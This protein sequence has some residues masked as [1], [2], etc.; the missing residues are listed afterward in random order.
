MPCAS[1]STGISAPGL[2][3]YSAMTASRRSRSSSSVA[4]STQP[5]HAF[6]ASLIPLSFAWVRCDRFADAVFGS[7]VRLLEGDELREVLWYLRA[8][9][10]RA[11]P[12]IGQ[13]DPELDLRVGHDHSGD[14]GGDVAQGRAIDVAQPHPGAHGDAAELAG[15][16]HAEPA[17]GGLGRLAEEAQAEAG[18]LVRL[19]REERVEGLLR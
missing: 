15:P 3:L 16:A 5:A 14:G 8:A 7:R 9:Q 18:L 1:W 17:A 10:R 6:T 2:P 11:R 12:G 4:S 13:V 19:G